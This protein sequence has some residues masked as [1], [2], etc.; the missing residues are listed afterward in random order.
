MTMTSPAALFAAIG[1]RANARE[2]T[3]IARATDCWS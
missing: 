2:R 3:A 1:P